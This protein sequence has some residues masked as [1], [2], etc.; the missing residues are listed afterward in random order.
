MQQLR[1]MITLIVLNFEFKAVPQ[2]LNSSD[3]YSKLLRMPHQSYIRL[4][5]LE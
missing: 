4:E 3:A 2:D 5:P 1:V